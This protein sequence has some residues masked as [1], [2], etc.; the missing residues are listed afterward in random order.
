MLTN[1]YD[2]EYGRAAG[3]VINAVTKSGHQSAARDRLLVHSRQRFGDARESSSPI[4]CS[5]STKRRPA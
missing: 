4:P 3:V 2:A 5:P 1:R